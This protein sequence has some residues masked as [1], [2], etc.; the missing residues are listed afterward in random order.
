MTINLT[1]TPMAQKRFRNWK[2]HP[3]FP[4]LPCPSL[5]SLLSKRISM[6]FSSK[7]PHLLK[8]I[9]SS[10]VFGKVYEKS[11]T[12]SIFHFDHHF[13]LDWGDIGFPI[14]PNF[15]GL[16]P[17]PNVL[18]PMPNPNIDVAMILP[19]VHFFPDKKLPTFFQSSPSKDGLKLLNKPPNLTRP[20]KMS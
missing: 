3:L 18:T 4:P 16:L 8:L 7:F 1:I 9:T 11:N 5:S 10:S 6:Y 2:G 20:A 14:S 17:V 12:K 19:G 13:I 15:G